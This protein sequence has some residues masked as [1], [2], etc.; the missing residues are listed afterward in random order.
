MKFKLE[1]I[2]APYLHQL[3]VMVLIFLIGYTT[4]TLFTYGSPDCIVNDVEISS[5][6]A[7]LCNQNELLFQLIRI[8]LLVSIA[9]EIYMIYIIL[10]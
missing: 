8:F 3:I 9:L 7:N 4:Y 6:V 5:E 1:H 10:F 2:L